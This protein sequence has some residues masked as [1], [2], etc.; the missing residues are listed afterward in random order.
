MPG[1]LKG[2]KI[3][4]LSWVLSG[5]LATMVLGDL[6]AE[7]IKL[8]RPEAGDL[9]RGNGPFIDGESSYFLSLNRGKKSLTIDL[10]TSRGKQL[11]LELTKTVDAVVE[12]FV[13][14]TMKRLGLDYEAVEKE[15]PV[16]IY[17]S[18]S[19]FGQTGPFAQTRALD[20]I[21]QAMGGIM[22]ITGES[23]GPPLRPGASLG[24]IT[25]GLFAAIGIVSALFERQQSGRGQMLD[26]SM[27]DCQVAILENAFSRF[28]ATG[29]V[30]ARLGT[31]HPVFTPFQAFESRDGYIVIAM[32]G[33]VR[34]QWPLFCAII[35]RLDLMDDDRYQT[36]EL[37]T[38]HYDELE[39]ILNEIMKTK[40]TEQWIKELTEIGI[41][42]GPINNIE[43]VASHPQV[44][45]REMIVEVPHPKLGSVKLINSPIKLSRTPANVDRIASGLGQDTRDLLAGLLRM[46]ESEIDKLA[47][48]KV[49]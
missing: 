24:D 13:P 39:P 1:P 4:D 44:R 9:A 10:Q 31:K 19:G 18:I 21:I 46:N 42:C 26:I 20:V 32:V 41:P 38:Q 28:F 48:D 37:R 3:L 7:V 22:S 8:E 47:E 45:A 43:Q 33:G 17:A 29:E 12:N 25:A 30:P 36:G 27:L 11:F 2:V 16:I 40:T 14:G 34:N 35:G 23:D 49:I 6:G 15:N 5:P